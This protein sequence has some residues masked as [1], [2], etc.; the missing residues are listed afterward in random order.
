[1][2]CFV[3]WGAGKTGEFKLS[4]IRATFRSFYYAPSCI[5]TYHP[6]HI[7]TA[8]QCL[9]IYVKAAQTARNILQSVIKNP[10]YLDRNG[11]IF[12]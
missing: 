8:Q 4:D 11:I 10:L 3:F 1:M 5:E 9:A 7:D 6:S 12:G 2:I